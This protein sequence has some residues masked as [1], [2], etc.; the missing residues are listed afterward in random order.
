MTR[1]RQAFLI[2]DASV[3]IDFCEVDRTV[4]KLVSEHIGQIHVPLPILHDEVDELEMEDCAELGIVLVE[5]ELAMAASAAQRR[6]GLSFHD[7][8]CLLLARENGW[9]CVTND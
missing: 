1:S 2:M 6:A 8:L 4:L 5:P 9:T 3:L 7:H